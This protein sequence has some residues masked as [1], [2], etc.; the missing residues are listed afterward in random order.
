MPSLQEFTDIGMEPAY[1]KTRRYLF[2]LQV[3]FVE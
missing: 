3:S 1:R 2:S